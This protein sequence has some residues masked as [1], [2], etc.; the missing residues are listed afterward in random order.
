MA[1]IFARSPYIVT[2]NETGQV[3]TKL[4]IY[5][6]NGTGSMPSSPTYTL[7]KLI[8][9]SNNPATYYDI[10]PYIK[11]Y[12]SHKS[13]QNITTTIAATPSAQWCN[14]GLKL[15]RR[16]STSF[17]QV[18]TTQTHFGLNGFTY[19]ETGGNVDLGNYLLDSRKYYY[20][21]NDD[22]GWVTVYAKSSTSVRYTNL[23]TGATETIGLVSNTWRDIPRVY[24]LYYNVGNQ[25][26][27]I[28]GSSVLY[29]ATFI[30]KEEC[31]YTPVQID[32][33]NRFGAW[34]REWFYKA[35]NTSISVESNVY[36]LMPSVYPD[37]SVL[38]G[39]RSAFNVNG[40]QSIRVNTD[41][42]DESYSDVI[43]QIMLSERILI[44]GKPA[45]L[46]TKNTELF[47]SINTKM[48]N[49][50]M[51]FEYAFD[52]INSVI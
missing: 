47:K 22:A 18:G 32:F 38:E 29:S 40:K 39:Q 26:E 9:S 28:S 51:E 21:V 20:N 45:I 49:Y 41:W 37:Y 52:T 11:E 12:I 3:E 44:D 14:V 4:E 2:I 24:S 10:S 33:V 15:F 19:Y 25:F 7:S 16:V 36:N 13:L 8:P 1:N 46:L 17:I 34:Q 31:K 42:V 6:W 23:S 43:K 48:I 5:L 50:Q 27:I 35:S 30:P